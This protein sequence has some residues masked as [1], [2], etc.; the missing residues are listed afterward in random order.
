[1]LPSKHY[2]Y[3]A[4]RR[5]IIQFIN[6]F[7]D[8]HIAR[9][10]DTDGSI[11]RYV[12]VPVVF[13]PKSKQWYWEA[14]RQNKI[15]PMMAIKMT[16]LE[17][18]TERMGNR[19]AKI[20]IGE[21]TRSG[22]NFYTN[23]VP[24]DFTFEV[25]IA[26]KYMVDVVQLI[27]QILPYFQPESYINLS[28]PIL[29]I[30]KKE[31]QEGKGTRPLDLKVIYE[32]N[33]KD[34][35]VE[36]PEADYRIILWTLNFRVQGY[37]FKPKYTIPLIHKINIHW[38]VGKE[39]MQRHLDDFKPEEVMS[40]TINNIIRHLEDNGLSS[41]EEDG[42]YVYIKEDNRK[43]KTV[44]YELSEQGITGYKRDIRNLSGTLV[45]YNGT[46][47][48]WMGNV[49]NTEVQEGDVLYTQMISPIEGDIPESVKE[50]MKEI[51][52]LRKMEIE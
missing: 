40:V 19:D 39:E 5:T 49:F 35:T 33:A 24:Y 20:V 28:I 51:E 17:H 46:Y 26:S 41:Y 9:Y 8:L 25:E 42:T 21:N 31:P 34:A 18:S 14:R 2:Y 16:G 30:D 48:E 10:D 50:S 6:I 7:S 23:P 52:D 11:L 13:A 27:E 36:I 32:G 22:D 37:L 44:P 15:L 1:M 29:N 3:E 4:I 12:K 38:R 45:F 43:D 47:W